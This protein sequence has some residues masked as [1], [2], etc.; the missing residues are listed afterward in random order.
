MSYKHS[1]NLNTFN[2]NDLSGNTIYSAGT[3]LSSLFAP[4]NFDSGI[5]T[6]TSSTDRALVTW[7][8]TDGDAVRDNSIIVNSNS[9]LIFP[10]SAGISGNEQIGG[11]Q[12]S[13]NFGT[14]AAAVAIAPQPESSQFIFAPTAV[15]KDNFPLQISGQLAYDTESLWFKKGSS[16]IDLLNT[17]NTSVFRIGSGENSIEAVYDPDTNSSSSSG[18][19]SFSVGLSNTASTDNGAVVGGTLNSISGNTTD[20]NAF[21]GGGRDN[22]ISEN[23]SF[24]GPKNTAIIG[25]RGNRLQGGSIY[26]SII[27]GRYNTTQDSSITFQSAGYRNII[28]KFSVNSSIVGGGNNLMEYGNSASQIG[29]YF[30]SSNRATQSS[31]IGGTSNKLD[32]VYSSSILGGQGNDINFRTYNSSIIGGNSNFITGRTINSSI[33]GGQG[34]KIFQ[35]YNS[36]IVAG[37]YNKIDNFSYKSAVIAGENNSITSGHR[38]G[39]V[40]G[41]SQNTISKGFSCVIIGGSSND[42]LEG[43][44]SPSYNIIAGGLS[45]VISS[46]QSAILT[47]KNNKIEGGSY[48]SVIL[49]GYENHTSQGAENSFI[50]QGY[51]NSISGSAFNVSVL[52][53]NNNNIAGSSS[54]TT[55]LGSISFSADSSTWDSV[56]LGGVRNRITQGAKK[57]VIIGGYENSIIEGGYT[58]TIISSVYSTISNSARNGIIIGG[59]GNTLTEGS[60]DSISIGGSSNI[61]KQSSTRSIVIGG[62]NNIINAPRCIVLGTNNITA[63]EPDTVYTPNLKVDG[64]IFSGDTNIE[65]LF[66]TD[67]PNDGFFYGRQSSSWTKIN[68]NT[69]SVFSGTDTNMEVIV[70]RFVSGSDVT[71]NCKINYTFESIGPNNTLQSVNLTN[72]IPTNFNGFEWFRLE[73]AIGFVSEYDS[74]SGDFGGVEIT[75]ISSWDQGSDTTGDVTKLFF[76][77]I[78]KGQGRS[79]LLDQ[80][81]QQGGFFNLD[82][83]ELP[84]GT[85]SNYLQ[86][87]PKDLTAGSLDMRFINNA[88]YNNDAAFPTRAGTYVFTLKGVLI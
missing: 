72:I 86:K 49:G 75:D 32:L 21:I 69:V 11:G 40:L 63:S 60:Y 44:V 54:G 10:P 13:I 83:T 85:P 76:G 20:S 23:G 17:G 27:G 56:S 43:Q 38:G 29:G 7:D 50:S 47:G 66:L 87:S 9:Q 14:G 5:P 42:I 34:N 16:W 39:L 80:F 2:S 33:L 25:G 57:A 81:D 46:R 74:G 67:A 71:I 84:S 22:S 15:S 62:S 31:I 65:E 88:Y 26:S 41:G 24:Y 48:G 35:T 61:S 52:G 77:G 58:S 59:S 45:N 28:R 6:I 19:Y 8:G 64:T 68:P 51:S 73:N 12:S 53:G 82:R 4:S 55:V 70:T 1:K 36:S 18:K 37:E 78:V 3:D 30:N 79:F